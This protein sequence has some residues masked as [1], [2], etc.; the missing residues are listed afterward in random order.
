MIIKWYNVTITT[1]DRSQ[2]KMLPYFGFSPQPG[3]T[4]FMNKLPV[5]I[6]GLVDHAD[7]RNFSYLI[8]KTQAGNLNSQH[9]LNI[10]ARSF[11]NSHS[12]TTN[13]LN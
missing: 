13:Q 6:G 7:N 11:N 5:Y 3:P 10:F 4:Y 12:L 8:D 9:T 1:N 2:E